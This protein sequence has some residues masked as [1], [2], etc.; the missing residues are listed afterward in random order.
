MTLEEAFAVAKQ[1]EPV[2]PTYNEWHVGQ[3][4]QVTSDDMGR[5]SVEG[6][7]I[8]ANDYEIVLRLCNEKADNLNVHFSRAGFDVISV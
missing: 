7:F 8:T 5:I 3:R 1:A 4:S 2:E 6:T